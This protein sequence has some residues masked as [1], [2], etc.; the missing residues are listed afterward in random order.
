[1]CPYVCPATDGRPVFIGFPW[2]FESPPEHHIESRVNGCESTFARFLFL[3][4]GKG[5]RGVLRCARFLPK[6][7]MYG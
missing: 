6:G 2:G 4:N 1:M 7:G 5:Q 3:D